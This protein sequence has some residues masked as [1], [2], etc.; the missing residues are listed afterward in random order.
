VTD[1]SGA[2]VILSGHAEGCKPA[3][4][5][6]QD[7]GAQCGRNAFVRIDIKDPIVLSQIGSTVFL[8]AKAIP[9]KNQVSHFWVGSADSLG[10]I[11]ATRIDN[12]NLIH[13]IE[14]CQ[15]IA[16]IEFLIF[17]DNSSG[18]IQC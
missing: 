1:P 10:S 5:Y 17:Y 14:T 3:S 9:R 4:G 6:I 13:E 8:A 11:N 7:R 15:A 16:D 2:E 12:N 18:N